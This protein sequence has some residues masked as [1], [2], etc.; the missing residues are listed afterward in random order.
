MPAT[1]IKSRLTLP[2]LRWATGPRRTTAGDHLARI[3]WDRGSKVLEFGGAE[4][5]NCRFD[6][7]RVPGAELIE[8]LRTITEDLQ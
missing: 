4:F 7:S 2:E 3:A 1:E 8:L 5:V 6:L